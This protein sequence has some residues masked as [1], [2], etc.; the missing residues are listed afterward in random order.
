MN[1][2]LFNVTANVVTTDDYYT[3]KWIFEALG[4]EFDLDVSAPPQGIPWLPSKAWYSEIDDGLNQDWAGQ[5]V[6]MNP[7]YGNPKAWVHKFIENGNGIA[8]LGSA[9]SRW[10]TKL[11]DVADA[12]VPTPYDLKFVRP[13]GDPKTI[14]YQTYLFALGKKGANALNQANIGK[15]R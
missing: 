8:L 1:E 3:P 14:S 12:V 6:W 9:R 10:F 4:V 5:F 11:W 2:T 15:A 13:N 7:P